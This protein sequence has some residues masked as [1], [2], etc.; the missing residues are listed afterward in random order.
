MLEF[1][2]NTIAVVTASL[3]RCCKELTSDTPEARRFVADQLKEA[4]RR[5]HVSLSSQTA[6]GE[7]AVAQVNRAD[8]AGGWR[9]LLQWVI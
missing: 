5:G 7:A 9:A 8:G 2:P 4:A 3:E 1:A 6:V